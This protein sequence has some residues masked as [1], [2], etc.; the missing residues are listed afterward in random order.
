VSKEDSSQPYKSTGTKVALEAS[1]SYCKASFSKYVSILKE[2]VASSPRKDSEMSQKES[3]QNA[4]EPAE[5]DGK[6]RRRRGPPRKATLAS[7]FSMKEQKE[8]PKR[9]SGRL[10]EEPQHS[11]KNANHSKDSQE[12]EDVTFKRPF[13]PPKVNTSEES[14]D[15]KSSSKMAKGRLR[16]RATQSSIAR[17]SILPHKSM[18]PPPPPLRTASLPSTSDDDVQMLMTR[19]RYLKNWVP[20]LHGGKKFIVEG[21]L[22]DFTPGVEPGAVFPERW[23]TSKIRSRRLPNLVETSGSAYVLE[24][25]LNFRLALELNLPQFVVQAFAVKNGT[26]L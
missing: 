1:F 23:K 24:G 14:E 7:R 22:L 18:I 25:R 26:Y 17:Q 8:E 12:K 2:S 15:Q 11:P 20:T 13:D 16:R 4:S 3:D 9:R 21:E 10:R 19:A 5:P 6:G